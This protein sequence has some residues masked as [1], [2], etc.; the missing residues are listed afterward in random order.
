MLRRIH[1]EPDDVVDLVH[2]LRV[3]GNLE[4][5]RDVGLQAEGSPD[6]TDGGVTWSADVKLSDA[7]KGAPYVFRDG[8]GNPYG[9][10][11]A[12]DVDASGR[13]IAAFGEAPSWDGPGGIWVTT[14]S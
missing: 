1:V 14:Q 3:V 4:R 5:A 11:Q 12:I 8:F 13:A 6:S 2:E 7:R 9:D 10:Y